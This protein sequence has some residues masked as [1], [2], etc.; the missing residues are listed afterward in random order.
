MLLGYYFVEKENLLL[1][2]MFTLLTTVLWFL[3]A[4]S[5]IELEF[6]YTAIQTDNTIVNGTHTWGDSTAVSM[7]YFFI[8]MAGIEIVYGLGTIP[9]LLFKLWKEFKEERLH[10]WEKR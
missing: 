2:T 4:A 1:A 9:R 5:V 3:L 7:M 8:M 10:S 6:P